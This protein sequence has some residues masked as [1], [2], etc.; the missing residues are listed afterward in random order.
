MSREI[1]PAQLS[2]AR[3]TGR[4]DDPRPELLITGFGPFPGV[5]VN[6]SAALAGAIADSGRWG[7]LGWRVSAHIFPTRYDQVAEDI[8]MLADRREAIRAIV[9]LGVATR[10]KHL[11]VEMLARNRV[12]RSLRDAGAARP[13]AAIIAPGAEAI[14]RGRHAGEVL[15]QMLRGAGV[16]ARKSYSAGRYVCNF[17]YWHMLEAYL[18]EIE[19]VFVHVPMPS[20]AGMRKRD[21][22]P[23]LPAMARSLRALVALMLRRARIRRT[24]RRPAASAPSRSRSSW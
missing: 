13:G 3:Q 4:K 18:P 9:M 22:R 24:A 15:A 11:R 14:R 10:T 6:P 23:A 21:P 1:S 2:P 16:D 19:V 17:A 8:A 7:R 12:S 5:P 20:R